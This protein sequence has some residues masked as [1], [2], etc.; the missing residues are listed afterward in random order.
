M[1]KHGPPKTQHGRPPRRGQVYTLDL[2]FRGIEEKAKEFGLS[3]V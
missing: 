1:R 3:T 2:A